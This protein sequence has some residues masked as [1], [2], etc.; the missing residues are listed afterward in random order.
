MATAPNVYSG[1]YRPE[2]SRLDG[3]TR[4]VFDEAPS[5]PGNCAQG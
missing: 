3:F 2:G 5:R 4:D 1:L